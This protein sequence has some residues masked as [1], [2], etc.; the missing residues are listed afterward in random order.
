ME[1]SRTE[2]YL[3]SRSYVKSQYQIW[4][5]HILAVTALLTLYTEISLT[6]LNQTWY[7]VSILKGLEA[8]LLLESSVKGLNQIGTLNISRLRFSALTKISM[9]FCPD[10]QNFKYG[11]LSD[12]LLS[13]TH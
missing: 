6:D 4:T 5:S 1:R 2:A 10:M 9:G 8:Y 12:G 3:F 7:S 13:Y 11:L